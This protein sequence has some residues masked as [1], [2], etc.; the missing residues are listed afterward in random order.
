MV[1]LTFPSLRMAFHH[2]LGEIRSGF[3]LFATPPQ[4][5][6]FEIQ[7]FIARL[8]QVLKLDRLA[9]VPSPESLSLAT[10][11]G[12]PAL[13]PEPHPITVVEPVRLADAVS[14]V[15][16]D[17]VAI[18]LVEPATF[19]EPAMP[20]APSPSRNRKSAPRRKPA[21]DAVLASKLDSQPNPDP[22][23]PKQ[24]SATNSLSASIIPD[25]T[26]SASESA[27]APM[28]KG[29]SSSKS[30]IF[31]KSD[32]RIAPR[33]SPAKRQALGRQATLSTDGP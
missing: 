18:R 22:P 6:N 20:A 21:A 15:N 11:P 2:V 7:I 27:Q 10:V 13:L 23:N 3:G 4:S 25:K 5:V 8:E 32:S 16:S 9:A 28:H 12:V 17:P 29:V 1:E 33:R 14:A 31:G 26:L 24:R 19:S 30:R